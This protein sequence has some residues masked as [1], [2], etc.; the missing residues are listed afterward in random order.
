[1]T[2]SK[3]H[4]YVGPMFSG[5]TSLLVQKLE[6]CNLLT[7][8]D[9]IYICHSLDKLRE[10]KS[11]SE[12]TLFGLSQL[13]RT[14]TFQTEMLSSLDLPLTRTTTVC[15]DEGQFFDQDDLHDF[16]KKLLK[17]SFLDEIY[18]V[19]LDGD[20]KGEYFLGSGLYR[21]MPLA[22]T[23]QKLNT[24]LCLK[25]VQEKKQKCVATMTDVVSSSSDRKDL[26]EIGG[27]E[28]YVSVCRRHHHA[29]TE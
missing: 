12:K 8:H 1:M 19:G 22:D 18:V 14:Q 7:D 26:I 27:S 9:S 21:L 10:K 29:F 25:C 16:V 5:K 3:L 20:Y 4:V 23:F 15:I 13:K 2:C 11:H 28:K 6:I 24:A 17:S